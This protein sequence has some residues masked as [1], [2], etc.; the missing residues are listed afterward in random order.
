MCAECIWQ[1]FFHSKRTTKTVNKKKR[2]K[3]K[4][5]QPVEEQIENIPR[6]IFTKH[7]IHFRRPQEFHNFIVLSIQYTLLG[8]N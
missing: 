1:Y 7:P 2:K 5:G 4:G 8:K 3:K 6:S